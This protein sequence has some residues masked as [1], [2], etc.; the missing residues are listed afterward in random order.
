MHHQPPGDGADAAFH[1]AGVSVKHHSLDPGI[2]QNGLQPGQS[3]EIVGTYQ[4]LH[5]TL[6]LA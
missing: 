1:H 4:F 5:H 6:A 2:R 3:N